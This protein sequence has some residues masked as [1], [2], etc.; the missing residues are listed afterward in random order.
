MN[1]LELRILQVVTVCL[2]GLWALVNNAGVMG[3]IG[4]MEWQTVDNFLEVTT[5]SCE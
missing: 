2:S 3:P 4:P 1:K 5:F